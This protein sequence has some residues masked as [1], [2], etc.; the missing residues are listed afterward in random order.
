MTI[1]YEDDFIVC[2]DDAITINW[3]YFPL[4]SKR[5]AY[6]KIRNIQEESM[7]FL[8]G[9]LRIWGMGLSPHWFHLDP[10]RPSKNKCIVLDEGEWIKSVI[11][12]KS[13]DRV[14]QILREKIS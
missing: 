8:T 9:G 4:G 5:I 6:H 7:N 11:T 14:M 12:P 2:D 13:H 1:L 3:Y 10:N